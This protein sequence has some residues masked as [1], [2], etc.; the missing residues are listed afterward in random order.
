MTSIQEQT[1]EGFSTNMSSSTAQ[2]VF[3]NIW[4]VP[5]CDL[6]SDDFVP[7]FTGVCDVSTIKSKC[8]W[9]SNKNHPKNIHEQIVAQIA[10]TVSGIMQGGLQTILSEAGGAKHKVAVGSWNWGHDE[11]APKK[12]HKSHAGI[13]VVLVLLLAAALVAFVVA[14]RIHH[15]RQNPS[16]YVDL[17]SM[18]YTPPIL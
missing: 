2:E 5:V 17:N 15:N 14:A 4:N 13:T 1:S 9:C 12:H 8:Q 10:Q 16:Q 18:G 7:G 3:R 6:F 11:P